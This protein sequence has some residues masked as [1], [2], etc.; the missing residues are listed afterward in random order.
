M[1]SRHCIQG[2]ETTLFQIKSL[3]NQLV[4]AFTATALMTSVGFGQQRYDYKVLA[5]NKTPEKTDSN[6]PV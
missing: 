4:Q 1:L 2:D 6:L 3:R 5:T